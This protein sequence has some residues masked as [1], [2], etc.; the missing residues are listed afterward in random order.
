MN[1]NET[2]CKVSVMARLKSNEAQ[3]HGKFIR[4]RTIMSRS[5][6]REFLKV[7]LENMFD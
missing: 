5:A 7:S 2:A 1:G 3:E 4:A 6:F